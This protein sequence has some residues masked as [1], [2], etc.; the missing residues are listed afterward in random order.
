MRQVIEVMDSSL[1][2]GQKVTLTITGM[3]VK[4]GVRADSITIQKNGKMGT[5]ETLLRQLHQK[6][7]H[8]TNITPK[9]E[10]VG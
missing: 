10:I 6:I 9:K 7:D 2:D 5:Q 3:V 8:I 4:G 1:R